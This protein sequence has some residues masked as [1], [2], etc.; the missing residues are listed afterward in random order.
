MNVLIVSHL[1]PTSAEPLKGV[2]VAEFTRSLARKQRVEVLAP[3]SWFPFLRRKSP[4]NPVDQEATFRTHH[5]HYLGLPQSLFHQRWRSYSWA[6]KDFQKR[7]AFRS[8]IIHCHWLY[9]DAYAVKRW[10]KLKNVKTVV[11]IHGRAVLGQGGAVSNVCRKALAAVDHII[12]V[13]AELKDMLIGKFSVPE[14]KITVQLNGVNPK[15]FCLRDQRE[16]RHRL[17][18]AQDRKMV[19]AVARL[20]PEKRLDTLVQA[21]EECVNRDFQVCIAGDGPLRSQLSKQIKG[22]GL[23]DRVSLLGGVSHDALPDWFNASDLFCLTSAHEG[24]PVVVH[25][26]MACGLPVVSTRVGAV[27]DL[28]KPGFGYLSAP[29]DASA[30]AVNLNSALCQEWDRAAIAAAGRK[31]TWDSLAETTVRDVYQPLIAQ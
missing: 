8:D 26:A 27:P 10:T 7:S 13:S 19:L 18:L 1:F 22:L 17:G 11:T 31:H 23:R 5:P 28:V 9:P 30:L 6:I 29:G 12:T 2:F 20:S 24:C 3:I 21:V 14:S 25:E 15:K 16:A 4:V